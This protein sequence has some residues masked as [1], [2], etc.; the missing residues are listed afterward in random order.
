MSGLSAEWQ[1]MQA[2]VMI[3]AATREK[4]RTGHD[5]ECLVLDGEWDK[6]FGHPIHQPLLRRT[7][8]LDGL[9]IWRFDGLAGGVDLFVV[10]V[11]QL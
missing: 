3:M 11:R 7:S 2:Y 8:F 4:H 1:V 6:D 9:R 5:D 10:Y